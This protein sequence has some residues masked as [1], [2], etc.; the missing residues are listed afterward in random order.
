MAWYLAMGAIALLILAPLIIA[1]PIE[2][3]KLRVWAVM[4]LASLATFISG[5]PVWF[6]AIDGV[7]AA[8][9]LQKPRGAVQR[10]IGGIFLLMVFMNGGFYCA[11]LLGGLPSY[12]S[13]TD[14]M[15]HWGWAQW[16]ILLIGCT[17]DFLGMFGFVRDWNPNDGDSETAFARSSER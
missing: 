12:E 5:H 9:V 10:L 17:Y 15:R 11:E 2:T 4:M 13:Y 3:R 8:V 14:T 16:A 1:K 7:S 6:L